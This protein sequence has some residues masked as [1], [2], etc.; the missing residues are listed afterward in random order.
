MG[1]ETVR[2]VR[3][4]MRGLD[5]LKALNE[6]NGATVTEIAVA[7]KLP[8]TTTYR[9]LETLCVAGYAIR[10]PSDDRYHLTIQARALSE[11]FDDEAWITEIAK[12]LIHNLCRE[13]VWPISVATI[14][15]TSMLVRETTDKE[16]PLALDR[17]SA[18]FRVPIL[19][20]A[21]GQC[22]LAFCSDE[23]REILLELLAKSTHPT[24]AIARNRKKVNEILEQVQKHGYATA[25][26]NPF[27][28][29]PGKTSSFAVPITSK[30]RILACL[31]LRYFNSA[32]TISEALNR[33]LPR[34]KH[35]ADMIGE[36]F[37][38]A[39]LP[40]MADASGVEAD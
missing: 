9:I 8:R 3:A 36:A 23:Q 1:S 15:G 22:Y 34:V 6:H 13:V 20:S 26:R 4:L 21:S 39:T 7:T 38:G 12:P 17:Y 18:G 33:Y 40:T 27:T 11:G 10:N 16:S 28:R 29:E 19:A 24:A 32:M 35:T 25:I 30:G 2:L 31:T 5:A 14:Y 37:A